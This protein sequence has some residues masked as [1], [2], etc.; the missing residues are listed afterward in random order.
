MGSALDDAAIGKLVSSYN[1]V[2]GTIERL[3]LSIEEIGRNMTGLGSQ[4]AHRPSD[5]KVTESKFDTYVRESGLPFDFMAGLEP[6]LKEL[7]AS[8]AEK[9]RLEDCLTQAGLTQLIKSSG[10]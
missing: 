2:Q 3:N 8:L 7:Q 4:L 1:N 5:V 9:K 6:Q 10:R